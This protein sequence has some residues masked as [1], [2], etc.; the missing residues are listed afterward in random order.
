MRRLMKQP[1]FLIGFTFV[2]T[3]LLGSILYSIFLHNYIPKKLLL[4]APNGKLLHAA[5][6]SPLEVFPFGTDIRGFNLA[7]MMLIGAKYTMFIVL[8]VLALRMVVS[9]V[10]GW[11]YGMYLYKFRRITTSLFNSVHYIPMTILACVILEP[12]LVS[13]PMT[14]K[15]PYSQFTMD[16]FEVIIL[17]IISIP[18]VTIQIGNMIGEIRKREFITSAKVLGASSWQIFWREITPHIIPRFILMCMQ[19]IIQIMIILAH[20][21][22]LNIFFGGTLHIPGEFFSMSNEW[23]GLIGLYKNEYLSSSPWLLLIPLVMY[24]LTIFAFSFMAEG[25]KRTF[26]ESEPV[27]YPQKRKQES[28]PSVGIDSLSNT[29]FEFTADK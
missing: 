22:V 5:P 23:S 18:I 26:I 3:L 19:Q 8:L 28:S 27:T 24:T 2:F 12:V 13:D 20:L 16:A 6:L 25:I 1:L 11:I 7:V 29:S 15:F 17:A 21:G 10:L 14:E 9:S 4:F